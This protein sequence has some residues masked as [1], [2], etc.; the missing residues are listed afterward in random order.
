MRVQHVWYGLTPEGRPLYT[1]HDL[2]N[3]AAR[4]LTLCH[5]SDRIS[6]PAASVPSFP[7]EFTHA[8]TNDIPPTGKEEG[9]G[10][11][12]RRESQ[13]PEHVII[14]GGT[15]PPP[16]GQYSLYPL[17]LNETYR[18]YYY[19]AGSS[20][21]PDDQEETPMQMPETQTM[22]GSQQYTPSTQF[23]GSMS[24][25]Y[26]PTPHFDS[27]QSQPYVPAP[28]FDGS[29]SQQFVSSTNFVGEQSFAGS[30]H[31]YDNFQTPPVHMQDVSPDTWNPMGDWDGVAIRELL[32]PPRP[33]FWEDIDPSQLQQTQANFQLD[34]NRAAAG[35]DPD[36]PYRDARDR[37]YP[38]CRNC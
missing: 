13:I 15:L 33:Q 35:G 31:G 2:Q 12:R 25:P 27:S 19:G 36:R 28:H 26:I 5:A 17:D 10:L 38:N 14:Q 4:C 6:H 30:Q 37:P 22:Y 3:Q 29:H 23:D 7:M 32:D 24:Q 18:P 8:T 11:G 1:D 16:H 21:V 34:L 20:G 9:E